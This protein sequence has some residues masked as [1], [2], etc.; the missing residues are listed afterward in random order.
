M[1]YKVLDILKELPGVN[2]KECGKATCFAFATGVYLDGAP[3]SV[4]TRLTQEK[5][6]EMEA[7]LQAGRGEGQGTKDP[8]H[9]QALVFLKKKIAGMDFAAMAA[10]CGGSV[11]GEEGLT[12][13]FMGRDFRI[14]PEDVVA[15]DGRE[16][17]VW[18]KV[19]LYIYVTRAT[20]AP[21]AGS[22]IAYRE[23]PNTISK[24]KTFEARVSEIADHFGDDLAGVESVAV[25]LGGRP[26]S[27]GSSDGAWRFDA[28]PRVPV[29]LL[30]WKGEE[31]FGPRAALLFDAVLL[32][33]LDQEASVF[34]AE[35]FVKL[36]TGGDVA[37][38]IP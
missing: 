5:L 35:A 30:Y 23:L 29:L 27:F 18:V 4:C 33:Y 20:G 21:L 7:K 13:S 3:L 25:A 22:W 9:V 2:C 31:E 17:S 19:F 38:V 12:V 16:P 34:L 10:N 14:T 6:A 32:D 11:D 24:A 8:S 26:E 37:E 1:A 28:L 15:V 36:M